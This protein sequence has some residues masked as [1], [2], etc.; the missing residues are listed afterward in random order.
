MSPLRIFV[1]ILSALC[2]ASTF[3]PIGANGQ[4]GKTVAGWLPYW[5]ENRALSVVKANSDLFS[6]LSPFWYDVG[7]NGELVPLGKAENSTLV[8]YSKSS[9]KALIPL[10][11]NEFNPNLISSIINNPEIKQTHINSIVSKAVRM[12]YE[13]M[14]LDYE[15]LFASD[16]NAFSAFVKDLALAL[17]AKGKKL[18]VTVQAKTN[19]NVS[20]NGAGAL[21]YSQIGQYADK[22]RIM[23]YDYH[24][25]TSEPGSIAPANWVEQ[26]VSYGVSVIPRSKI[27]LGVPNYGYDWVGKKGKGITYS[28]AISTAT[29]YGAN[30]VY[31]NQNG[32]HYFYTVNGIEHE[33]WFEDT[34]SISTLLNIASKFNLNGVAVWRLGGEDSSS[35]NALREVLNNGYVAPK[36]PVPETVPAISPVKTGN[37][38][39]TKVN[40][41]VASLQEKK[42]TVPVSSQNGVTTPPQGQNTSSSTSIQNSSMP[43][44]NITSDKQSSE[45]NFH[46]VGIIKFSSTNYYSNCHDM[47]R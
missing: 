30:I 45:N 14:E 39:T 26:V 31:D 1:G 4:V 32:P 15:C 29:R 33:V 24:W 38:D 16:K 13:G 41:S 36:N 25:I 17:H 18:V 8:T 10:I 27:E 20:W 12:G 43:L 11:S 42:S 35:Y 44:E 46:P 2:I 6:E 23:A 5:D 19:G 28:E 22:V 3:L 21:D 37:Q 40:G 34:A 7:S 9:G 47:L